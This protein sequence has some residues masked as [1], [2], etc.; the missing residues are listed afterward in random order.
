[1]PTFSPQSI[2]EVVIVAVHCRRVDL[3]RR[4][5]YANLS[6]HRVLAIPSPK[7]AAPVTENCY[8]AR[9]SNRPVTTGLAP[10]RCHTHKGFSRLP[11]GISVIRDLDR[12]RASARKGKISR[13]QRLVKAPLDRAKEPKKMGV[14]APCPVRV[15]GKL[16]GVLPE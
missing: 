14:K 6:T 3:L 13:H 12:H 11:C 4:H 7:V 1:M 15:E 2:G 10:A 9:K 16:S 5:V 8:N